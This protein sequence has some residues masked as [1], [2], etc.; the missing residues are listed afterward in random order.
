MMR[1]T[2]FSIANGSDDPIYVG[3]SDGTDWTDLQIL[4]SLWKLHSKF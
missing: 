2:R 3:Y 1:K 4:I